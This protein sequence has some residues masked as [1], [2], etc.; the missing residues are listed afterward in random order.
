[1]LEGKGG[2]NRFLEIFLKERGCLWC[3]G[4]VLE[5]IGRVNRFLKKIRKKFRRRNAHALA[6]ARARAAYSKGIWIASARQKQGMGRRRG[7]TAKMGKGAHFAT[8]PK[9]SL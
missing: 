9:K 8:F 6:R 4:I 3:E 5:W 2:V 7:D 1:M